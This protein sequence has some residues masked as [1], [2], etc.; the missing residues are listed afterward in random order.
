MIVLSDFS[1][2]SCSKKR[3]ITRS[4]VE[5]KQDAVENKLFEVKATMKEMTTIQKTTGFH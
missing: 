4:D 2:Q 5:K 1:K 3:K